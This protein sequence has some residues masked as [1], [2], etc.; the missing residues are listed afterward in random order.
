MG[1]APRQPS[2]A[3]LDTVVVDATLLRSEISFLVDFAEL[4]TPLLL[5]QPRQ[6]YSASRPEQIAPALARAEAAA[7]RGAW[8]GGMLCYEAAAA[9]GLPVQAG[10]RW[11]L[12]WLAEFGRVRRACFQPTSAS[13]SD[14]MRPRL[15]LNREAYQSRLQRIARYIRDGD[16]YQVNFTL[17]AELDCDDLAALFLDRHPRQRHPYSAW[18]NGDEFLVASFSPEL[19]LSRRG[20]LICSAPI[21]GTARRGGTADE[22]LI[23]S[24]ALDR[25]EKERAEH[26]MIV[27][28][29]RNDLGR[30]CGIGS[31]APERLFRHRRFP[32]LH[33][34]ETRVC[35]GSQADLATLFA[36]LFP[37]ASI[38][39]APKRRTME[40]IAELEQAPRGPYTGSIGL[41]QPG[42]DFLFN[43]AIRTVTKQSGEPCR[44][45]LGG[46][47]VADSV[48]AQEWRELETKARFL[49]TELA[50]LGLI[51]SL[52][53][54][55]DGSLPRLSA[56]LDRLTRSAA[57]LGIPCSRAALT[58]ALKQHIA[59]DA[60]GAEFEQDKGALLRLRLHGDGEI[61]LTQRDSVAPSTLR[62]QLSPY[63]LD[64]ADPL[65]RHKSDRRSIY[66]AALERARAAGYDDALIRNFEN[67][68]ADGAI[69]ALFLRRQ[70]RWLTPPLTAG[71]L[72]SIWRAEQLARRQASEQS[73]TLE[74][75]AE[76]DEVV[77]GNAVQGAVPVQR[78]DD[79]TGRA[80]YR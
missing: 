29:V 4:G 6:L 71:S 44:L 31:V 3:E 78:I 33:H 12:L 80:L 37:A 66:N 40:I 17:P 24:I 69:R 5:T 70:G 62:I 65:L 20:D 46:G 77:M 42:G 11:P 26:L 51:E 57:A 10:G 27:D 58:A 41:I 48:A 7:R 52:R 47:I 36:A 68:L 79:E 38:T 45:G 2:L 64:A 16:S 67:E 72:D 43:V 9:F 14:E 73:L 74:D 60:S 56:H 50:P 15:P 19:F 34:L 18:L 30:I 8:V 53:L 25:S 22:D 28:M 61:E 55:A 32:T 1:N 54:E 39:G 63:R 76:A 21:K 35:G 13:I 75:L 23:A 59:R 49:T